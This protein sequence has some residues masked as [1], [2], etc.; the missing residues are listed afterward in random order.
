MSLSIVSNFAFTQDAEASLNVC[1][2]RMNGSNVRC[3]RIESQVGEET[4]YF[5][6]SPAEAEWFCNSMQKMIEDVRLLNGSANEF[7]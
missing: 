1:A 2:E 7:E 3:V 4:H 5:N 6:L